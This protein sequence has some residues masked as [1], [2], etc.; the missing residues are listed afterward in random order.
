MTLTLPSILM[1]TSTSKV[2]SLVI[3]ALVPGILTSTYF[4]GIGILLNALLSVATAVLLEALVLRIRHA[5]MSTLLDGSA[6]LTGLLLGIALPPDLPVWMTIIG[7]GFGIIFGKHLYGGLG[8]NPF[9]P[10]MVGYAVLILSFPLAMSSWP[11]VSPIDGVTAATPLDTFRFRGAYTIE[12][13]WSTSAGF[14]SLAGI[15]WQWI[16]LGYLVGGLVLIAL[17]VIR[18]QALTGMLFTLSF[19]AMIFY[20][21]GSSQSLGS[22]LFHLLSGGTML[23]AFF[24]VTDP[25]T[26]PDSEIGLYAFGIGVGLIT[27]VIRSTGAYPDGFAFA[28]LLM[29]A[30]TPLIDRIR[31][32]RV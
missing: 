27:F 10:A 4:F 17:G 15:G 8:H 12:E 19:L 7:C 3:V 22:P 28:I 32:T 11:A 2:M 1:P 14:D 29:N 18:W 21:N 20:D 16:N 23:T 6:V 26:S 5:R 31:R 25:V 13:I 30:L 9:N 24:I